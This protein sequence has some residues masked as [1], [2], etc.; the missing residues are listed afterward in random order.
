[1]KITA[2]VAAAAIAVS[3]GGLAEAR[4]F[5]ARDMARLDRVGDPR[6]SPDGRYAIYDLRVVDYD[7][8][9]AAHQLWLVDLA[10]PG[11]GPRR[12]AA[13]DAGAAAARWSKDGR[14]YFIS[15]RGG[16]DQ[17]WSTDVGGSEARQV[18]ALPFDVGA[19]AV[20]PDGK[21]IVASQAVFPDCQ[22]LAC[23]ETRLAARAKAKTTGM[24][25]DRVFVRH[26]DTWEDGRRNHL[27]VQDL[28]ASG[29]AVGAPRDVTPGLDGD[30]PGKPFGDD[31]DF[32]VSPDGATLVYSVRVAGKSEPWSTNFDL[33]SVPLDGGP[34]TNLTEANPAWDAGPVFS[35]DGRTLAYRAMKRPGFEA[36]RWAVMVRDL[37][38]GSTREIAPAWDRSPDSLA[39]TADGKALLAVA[40]DIGQTKLFRIDVKSG[41]PTALTGDGHVSAA[42]IGGGKVVVAHDRLDAPADLYLIGAGAP[43]QLTRHNAQ[44]LA[45]LQFGGYE[46]FSFPGWNGETVHGY[47]VKPVG[48]EPGRK[49]PVAFLIHGGP[50]GSFGDLFHYR[51]NA[52]AYAGAGYAVVMIDFHGSTGYGQAF[53]DAISRHWGDRPL[54]DLQKGWAAALSRYAF[55]DGDRACALGGSY[56]GFMINWIAGNWA[57]PWKCLVNHDGIFDARSMGYSTEELWFSEWENG[58]PPYVEG[59]TY[60][61]FN[62]ATKVAQWRTPTMVIHGALDYR[63]PLEQGLS[64]FNALQRRGIESRLVVFPNENHWVLKPQNSVQWHDEV[65]GWLDRWTATPA[66]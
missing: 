45:D 38:T 65:L 10:K 20:T 22:D 44:A 41:A 24:V 21:R 28:D 42:S 3:V 7:A 51:W 15:A 26:W 66:R 36:D 34:A 52:Q 54:E 19:F 40:Q 62:P 1:M 6:V 46:Q 16:S 17:V 23:T 56:G 11:V 13:G 50:Q 49:Y 33:Y 47:V 43:R 27:F 59:T 61:T 32:A 25:Y 2:F 57:Q 64:T 60:E 4:P 48:Y 55:L 8:N 37:K 14:I 53:T 9:R 31:A 18:T 35:P 29:K 30:V 63:V 5:T 58:G 12:L 39:W